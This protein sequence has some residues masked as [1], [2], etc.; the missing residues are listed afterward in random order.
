MAAS[1][2]AKMIQGMVDNIAKSSARAAPAAADRVKRALDV[3][4]TLPGLQEPI[5]KRAA[6]EQRNG[7]WLKEQVA[8]A[9][10]GKFADIARLRHQNDIA[11][12]KHEQSKPRLPEFDRNDVFAGL[13]T[14][15]IAK[16][17]ATTDPMKRARLSPAE[18]LAALRMPEIAGLL[19]SQV[20]TWTAEILTATD[21]AGMKAYTESA[22]ALAEADR[23]LD[24]VRLGF[25]REA[26]FVTDG[27]FPSP[28]WRNYERDQMNALKAEFDAAEVAA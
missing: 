1:S 9:Y 7:T 17:V 19:P 15:E 22:E 8:K 2:V 25:Q 23:A 18:K 21:P 28:Q 24:I 4:A 3:Y 10:A 5:A 14:L 27:G 26:G 13:Q 16:R 11:R 12:K 20:E 6:E